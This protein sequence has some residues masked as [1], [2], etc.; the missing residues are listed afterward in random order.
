[1][2]NGFEVVPK[3]TPFPVYRAFANRLIAHVES[4][5]QSTFSQWFETYFN[6]TEFYLLQAFPASFGLQYCEYYD[7]ARSGVMAIY[8][9]K[10]RVIG[11]LDKQLKKLDNLKYYCFGVHRASAKCLSYTARSLLVDF[12]RARELVALGEKTDYFFDQGAPLRLHEDVNVPR[13]KAVP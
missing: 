11:N 13:G 6:A 8:P 10:A 1:M 4:S 5:E 7:R 3:T 9:D 12:W 2:K